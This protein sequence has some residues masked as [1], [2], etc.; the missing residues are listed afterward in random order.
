MQ[1]ICKRFEELTT[2]EL[3]EILKTRV[4]V[5]VVEQTCPYPE[6][7]EYD[8]TSWHFYIVEDNKI[9]S[10][11]RIIPPG[12]RFQEASIGRVLATKRREGYASLLLKEAIQKINKDYKNCNIKIE[13][14]TYAKSLYEKLGFVQCSEEFLED[15]IPHIQMIRK[16]DQ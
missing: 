6:I 11:C 10:Y 8:L 12:I 16:G 15:D 3:Y 5:F 14:Q 4:D 2:R 1:T 9:A 13:A 7:D